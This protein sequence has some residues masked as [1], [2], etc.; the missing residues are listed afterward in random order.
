MT[1]KDAVEIFKKAHSLREQLDMENDIGY[2]GIILSQNSI[3][4]YQVRAKIEEINRKHPEN[5]ILYNMIF[6]PQG[7]RVSL[8]EATVHNLIDD[9]AWKQTYLQAKRVG[10]AFEKF[11]E[12]MRKERTERKGQSIK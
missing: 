6:P 2:I 4:I 1:E 5:L 3:D 8:A 9:L 11:C 12:E 10:K 7:N